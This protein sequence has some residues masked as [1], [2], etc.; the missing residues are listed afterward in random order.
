VSTEYKVVLMLSISTRLALAEA[1][2]AGDSERNS[3][4]IGDSSWGAGA[5]AGGVAIDSEDS[6]ERSVRG[7]NSKPRTLGEMAT[8]AM[9]H[10]IGTPLNPLVLCQR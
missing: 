6:A 7:L 8:Y 4:L 2:N 1:S 5:S 10:W 3:R 9:F